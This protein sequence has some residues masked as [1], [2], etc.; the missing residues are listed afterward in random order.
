MYLYHHPSRPVFFLSA[1]VLLLHSM[2]CPPPPPRWCLSALLP[3][4]DLPAQGAIV[5]IYLS[6]SVHVQHYLFFLPTRL[7]I[8][9]TRPK[10]WFAKVVTNL[11]RAV[12]ARW[13][14]S[15]ASASTDPST[16][17]G[18]ENFCC[19]FVIWKNCE[20]VSLT[21][22]LDTSVTQLWGNV[23]PGKI[24]THTWIIFISKILHHL[25]KL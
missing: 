10:A 8:L 11:A 4:K 7:T 19:N 18:G 16:L 22:L 25:C 14:P 3:S 17:R 12:S 6:P 2:P 21:V 13:T 1:P 23:S 15:V 5:K 24:D 20:G 9:R